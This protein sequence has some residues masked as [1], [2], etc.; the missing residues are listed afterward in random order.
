LGEIDRREFLIAAGGLLALP[1][2]SLAQQTGKL[3]RIGL[4]ITST[5]K[6]I[7]PR[8][9][10]FK[11]AFRELGYV[12]G[13]DYVLEERYAANDLDR[14]SSLATD[15]V[16][17]NVDVIMAGT[18]T[19]TRAA[20]RATTA[21]PIVFISAGDPVGSGLVKSLARPGGNITGNSN[22]LTDIAPKHLDL[23]HQALPRLTRLAVLMNP[24]YQ[25]HRD[26][27]KIIGTLAPKI[28]AHVVPI[29]ARSAGDIEKGF[30]VMAEQ[31]AE[32]VIVVTDPIFQERRR[33]IADLAVKG[34]LPSVGYSAEYADAG[35]LVG[36][37][38]NPSGFYRR[39]AVYV[40]KILKGAKPAD[41]PVEQ[42]STFEFVVNLRT[43][44]ELGLKMPQ[45][46]LLRADRV[47]E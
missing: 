46:I 45:S 1:L 18:A 23:L 13:R 2:A 24:N 39:S 25:S 9:E 38:A 19:P 8:L 43:A 42:P 22:S 33:Q 28:G 27:Q 7:A 32:A 12:E 15:L 10:A 11:M 3:I 26:A 4:L 29:E 20:Q 41:L 40:D 37:G 44:R 35:F 31:K 21:I 47:I 34:R 6:D 14:L 5:R 16:R 36:Y 30:F 17:Q